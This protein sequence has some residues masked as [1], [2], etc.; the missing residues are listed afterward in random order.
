[1]RQGLDSDVVARIH[2]KLRLQKLAEIA[3]VHGVCRCRQVMVGWLAGT[4]FLRKLAS[5]CSAGGPRSRRAAA[6]KK[7]ALEE[8]APLAI[9]F[10]EQLLSMKLKL[11]AGVIFACA[12]ADAS[13]VDVKQPD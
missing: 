10:V 13:T 12:H 2:F 5:E 8:A 11:R 6:R 7:C 3:P 1:M 4:G 9:E